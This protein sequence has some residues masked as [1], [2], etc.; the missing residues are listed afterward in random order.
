MPRV[1]AKYGHLEVLKW[2]IKEGC[3]YD[4]SW[5]RRYAV[6]GGERA[7]EVLEWLDELPPREKTC[8]ES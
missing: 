5:C 1:A 8:E 4:K 3:P 6:R 7:R 2:L